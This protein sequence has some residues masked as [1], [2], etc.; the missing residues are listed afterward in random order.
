MTDAIILLLFSKIGL[1]TES[2]KNLY[3]VMTTYNEATVKT[4]RRVSELKV[5]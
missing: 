3:Q 4:D 1:V 5:I 2:L